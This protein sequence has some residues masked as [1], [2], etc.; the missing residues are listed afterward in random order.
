[1][2]FENQEISWMFSK[3]CQFKQIISKQFAKVMLHKNCID[4]IVH[5]HECCLFLVDNRTLMVKNILD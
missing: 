3:N 1:M 5:M 4:D 2:Y